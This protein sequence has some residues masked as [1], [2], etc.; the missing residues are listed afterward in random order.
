MLQ[1]HRIF[2]AAQA[3]DVDQ[4]VD[5]SCNCGRI[6]HDTVKTVDITQWW[7]TLV[8]EFAMTVKT[9]DRTQWLSRGQNPVMGYRGRRNYGPLC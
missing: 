2:T 8:V 7:G 9:V 4:L 3:E 5:L 6:C 1:R